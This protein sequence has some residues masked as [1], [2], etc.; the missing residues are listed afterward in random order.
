MAVISSID[1][2]GPGSILVVARDRSNRW[3][4]QEALGRLSRRFAS[5]DAALRFAQHAPAPFAGASVAISS[6]PGCM[7]TCDEAHA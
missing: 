3:L 1:Q 2:D 7:S 4:V 6:K 5:F